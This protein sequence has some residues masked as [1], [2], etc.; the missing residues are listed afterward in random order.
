MALREGSRVKII[1]DNENYTDWQD[2]VLKVTF[3]S[4]KGHY[5]DDSMY[6]E[7]LCDLECNKTGEQCPFA[8]Y[9]YELERI[10]AKNK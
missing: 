8:L 7:M 4:N 10:G 2:R 1:S 5:Y 3:A 6:P 9:E